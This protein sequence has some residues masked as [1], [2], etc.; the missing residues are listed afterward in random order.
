MGEGV[1]MLTIVAYIAIGIAG[2]MIALSPYFCWQCLKAIKKQRE[3]ESRLRTRQFMRLEAYLKEIAERL[4]V[5]ADSGDE[6]VPE[7]R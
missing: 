4:A 7:D 1:V 2:L 6:E 5:I 3:E